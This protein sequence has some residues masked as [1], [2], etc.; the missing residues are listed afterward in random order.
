[1]MH[2]V[3]Q[4]QPVFS[5]EVGEWIGWQMCWWR[6][7]WDRRRRWL[8]LSCISFA[9]TPWGYLFGKQDCIEYRKVCMEAICSGMCQEG[10]FVRNILISSPIWLNKYYQLYYFGK[11]FPNKW[12][13]EFWRCKTL[14][15]AW[16]AAWKLFPKFIIFP[17]WRPWDLKEALTSSLVS[18]E[19]Y[20]LL[21]FLIL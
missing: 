16:S 17:D 13:G 9:M 7:W 12:C 4:C 18:R 21:E 6:M 14:P 1:M 10:I 2:A 15:L 5:D 11:V 20:E 19:F 8:I 3:S